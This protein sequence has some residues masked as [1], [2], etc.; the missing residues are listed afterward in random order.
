MK[1]LLPAAIVLTAAILISFVPAFEAKFTNWDDTQYVG[2]AR[3]PWTKLCTTIVSGHYHPLTMLSLGVDVRLF[4][5][6]PTGMHVV[7]IALHLIA[8]LLV[9]V[10]LFELTGSVPAALAGALFFAIHPLR[11]ESV[12]WISERK[13]VLM[14]AFYAA[15]L[16]AY[17]AHLRR[18]TSIAWTYV[19]FVLALLSKATALSLPVVLLLID[20]IAIGR[21]RVKAKIPMFVLSVIAGWGAVAAI[22]SVGSAPLT[23][24]AFAP[25]ERLVISGHAIVMYI[26]RELVP[27]N[28]SAFYPLPH[29]VTAM[30]VQSTIAVVLLAIALVIVFRRLPQVLAGLAIFVVT[31]APMLP[32]LATGDTIGADRY[33]YIP[34][35][36][37]AYVVA[38]AVARLSIRAAIAAIVIGGLILGILTWQQCRVWHDGTSLWTSVIDYDPS[39]A[40]AWNNRGGNGK[41]LERLLELSEAISLDP[42]YVKALQNRARLLELAG[43]FD[44]ALRDANRSIRCTPNDAD[45]WKLKAKLLRESGREAEAQQCLA[46]GRRVTG[47]P[48]ALGTGR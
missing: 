11:V 37:L 30:H 39:I 27:V 21:P 41:P 12:A 40:I 2:A 44:A 3:L 43:S 20:V 14:G 26:Q 22:H 18:G 6:N 34:S 36:G 32:L 8:S 42:C 29:D 13:D 15:A 10:V 24:Y 47:V 25:P 4:G 19:F 28:L 45:A 38:F 17:V 33:T 35:I 5:M 48:I 1:R 31:I 9:L 23:H 16:V 46:E 7:N